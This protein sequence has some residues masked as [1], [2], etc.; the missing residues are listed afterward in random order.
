M[1]VT[2]ITH[3]CVRDEG[4]IVHI[5]SDTH[6]Y[7]YPR[8]QPRLSLQ[9]SDEFMSL[10]VAGVTYVWDTSGSDEWHDPSVISVTHIYVCVH[11]R[12]F[13]RVCV[14][15]RACVTKGY[16]TYRHVTSLANNVW[17]ITGSDE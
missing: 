15:V 7:H 6:A 17:D 4:V 11:M 9:C 8:H 16:L 2:C 10:A 5:S 1:C 14:C 3:I 13:I 12:V